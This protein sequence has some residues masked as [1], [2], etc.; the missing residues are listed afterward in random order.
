MTVR[1]IEEAMDEDLRFSRIA[2]E[3]AALRARDI[4]RA[5]GTML[6]VREGGILRFV[7]P[8]ELDRADRRMPPKTELDTLAR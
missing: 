2:L 4:A 7:T 8:D 6:V 5:A 3:R 1:P